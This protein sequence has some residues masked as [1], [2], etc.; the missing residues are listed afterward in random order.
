MTEPHTKLISSR[1]FARMLGIS[2]RSL[3]R[4]LDKGAIPEPIDMPGYR[5]WRR[6]QVEKWIDQN[7]PAIN[8]FN[9]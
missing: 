8:Q 7:C 6:V 3:K 1:E 2:Q 9:Y 4:A 5:R